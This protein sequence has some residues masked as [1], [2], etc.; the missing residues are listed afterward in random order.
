[1]TLADTG[2]HRV[3]RRAMEKRARL[4]LRPRCTG[5]TSTLSVLLG[6]HTCRTDSLRVPTGTAMVGHGLCHTPRRREGHTAAVTKS[7]LRG[8]SYGPACQALTISPP[9][10]SAPCPLIGNSDAEQAAAGSHRFCGDTGRGTLSPP[11]HACLC[12]WVP[13]TGQGRPV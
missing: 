11:S 1:M 10:R 8:Q 13:S 5:P 7:G 6:T 9:V 4:S 3:T 2:R 12:F